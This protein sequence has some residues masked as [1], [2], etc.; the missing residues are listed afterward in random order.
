M[1]AL[2]ILVADPIADEGV[3]ALAQI[4]A[5][6][7]RTGLTTSDLLAIIPDYDALIV[8][9]ETQVTRAVVEAGRRLRAIGRA[10]VGVDNID[11]EAATERGIVVVNAPLGNTVSAAEHTVAVLLALARNVPAADASLRRGEWSRKQFIGVEIRGKTVGIVGLGQVGSAVA[12]RLRAFETR[13]LVHDPFVPDERAR[14]VGAELADLDILLR[15]SDFLLL[16][17]TLIPGAPPLIGAPELARM[18]PTARIV[19][20]A[21]GG[22]IDEA[23]LLAA[24]DEGRIAGAGL[25]VFSAEPATDNPLVRHPR[26][27]A[28]PHLG[29]STLEAQERVALDVARE[30]ANVLAGKPATTAVNAPFIDPESLEILGP[31]LA[32]AEIVGKLATQLAL[33]QWQSIRIEYLGEI[34]ERDVT[35]LK[36]A[37]IAGLL[38]PISEE[39]V[40]LVSV[41]NVIAHRGWQ[42]TEEKNRDAGPYS[43]LMHSL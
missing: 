3:D 19:N 2:R 39:H 37:A 36:A 33:G 13:V 4:G 11:V 30:V 15:E 24:L 21:R 38:A 41:N 29:A 20:T 5:V 25:D 12:R 28:T 43:N 17:T 23:A 6:D 40:N 9:S 18:K 34:A 14:L 1:D 26:V 22:L 8:R 10:G 35:P 31:Y 7:V 16:H 42:V 27:V 32:V